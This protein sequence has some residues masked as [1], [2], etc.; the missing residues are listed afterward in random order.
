MLYCIYVLTLVG[1]LPIE[2]TT[3]NFVLHSPSKK[4]AFKD[5]QFKTPLSL[6]NLA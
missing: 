2:M 4:K 1:I 5:K 6:K 3:I